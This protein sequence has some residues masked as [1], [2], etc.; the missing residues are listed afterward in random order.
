MTR[1]GA[2]GSLLLI[3]PRADVCVCVGGP[4]P[5][6]LLSVRLVVAIISCVDDA[7]KVSSPPPPSIFRVAGKID[8]GLALSVVVVRMHARGSARVRCF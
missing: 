4:P 3:A 1:E 6:L 8:G 7:A 5:L 2:G